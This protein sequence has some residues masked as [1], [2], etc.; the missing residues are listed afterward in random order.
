MFQ[1]GN[2]LLHQPSNSN[3]CVSLRQLAVAL[4]IMVGATASYAETS[5]AGG[6]FIIFI[7]RNIQV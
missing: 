5:G 7:T 3:C 6:Y 1:S 4:P 2:I